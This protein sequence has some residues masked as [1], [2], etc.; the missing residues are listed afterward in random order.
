VLPAAP[1]RIVDVGGAAGAYSLWLAAQGYEVHLVDASARLV[2]EARARSA[3]A[4]T[5]IASCSVADARRLPQ[6]D[7]SAAVV[8]V[9]GPLLPPH[10]SSRPRHRSAGGVSHSGEWR[11]G[12]RGRH[13]TLR[14]R[15]RWPE[16]AALAGIRDSSRFA[17]GNLAEGQHRNQ[18]ENADYFTTAYFHRPD[19]LRSELETAGFQGVSVVGVEGPGWLLQDFDSR[20]KDAALR[21]DLVDTARILE[22]EPAI[23]GVSAHFLGLGRKP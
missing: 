9:M 14:F 10:G 16:A 23:V 17:I 3:R 8:L 6:E 11:H 15:T 4:A 20:W 12:G 2:E 18:T 22:S 7:G 1:A 13:L 21:K 5:P 19:D